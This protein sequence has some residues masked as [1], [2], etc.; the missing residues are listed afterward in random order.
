LAVPASAAAAEPVAPAAAKGSL[1][2]IGGGLKPDND[3]VWQ[4]IVALAGGPGA[5]IAVFPSASS[6]PT[7][8]GERIVELLVRYGADAFQVPLA[9]KLE[10]SDF[11]KVAEDPQLT[12]AVRSAGG[13]FFA[14]GDQARITQALVREDGSRSAMLEAV[15]EVYRGGGVVAGSSAGAAIM[16]STMFYAPKTVF[17]TLRNGVSEGKEIAPGLGFIGDDVF[18]DQHLLV[19]GR[20]AR[21]IP[22][23]LKKGY[24]IGLGIDENT[25]M[26]VDA[27]R[28][29]EILGHK[30]ALLIDL[31]RATTRDDRVGFNVSNAVI[32][33]LDR[34]DQYDLATHTFIP[35]REKADGRLDGYRSEVYHPVFS[36]DILGANAVVDLMERLINNRRS[37]G[38]GIALGGPN[39]QRPELAFQF[40]FSKTADS[41]GYASASA[42]SYSILNM[43]LDI[44]PIE[45]GPVLERE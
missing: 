32:S 29:V 45:L 2:I 42:P 27:R 26:V 4:R 14:G 9:V 17:A 44:N 8:T 41:V 35:S 11:R 3:A 25:A 33:Y 7:Q 16:S 19:R 28:R 38:V 21:M 20:F 43:R 1:V 36:P 13:V 37:E 5:R 40:T 34:G 31:S 18:V 12:A 24:K 10:G 15:W 23:M 22:A 39:D 6:A 30:G